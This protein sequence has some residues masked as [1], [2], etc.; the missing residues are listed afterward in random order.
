MALDNYCLLKM[1]A[2]AGSVR[3]RKKLQKLVYLAQLEGC[4][5]EDR[6]ALHYYG[7][8][9][10][11][12]AARIDDLVERKR[13]VEHTSSPAPGAVEY[14]YE[15]SPECPDLLAR[16][17][18]TAPPQV[19][20]TAD[21]HAARFVERAQRD[22]RELELAATILYWRDWGYEW[23]EA[24]RTAARLKDANLGSSLCVAA[25]RLAQDVWSHRLT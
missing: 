20:R 5:I 25:Q 16:A 7:P 23:D 19:V 15:L 14:R 22:V 21:E 12:L 6:F 24:E 17:E 2:A 8:Y 3:G 9:S 11:D 4:P 18:A 13:L 10:S 1:I